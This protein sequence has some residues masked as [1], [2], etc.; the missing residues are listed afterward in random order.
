MSP[1]FTN[2][3]VDPFLQVPP[4]REGSKDDMHPSLKSISR[5]HLEL[6]PVIQHHHVENKEEDRDDAPKK[7]LLEKSQLM[8]KS[9]GAYGVC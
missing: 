1:P 6:K 2:P 8:T 4:N 5:P 7:N 9:E 3:T